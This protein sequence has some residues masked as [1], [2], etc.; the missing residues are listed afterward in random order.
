MPSSG[1]EIPDKSAGWKNP[2]AAPSL[3]N[4]VGDLAQSS[5]PM[6]S[7]TWLV[8]IITIMLVVI[9]TI[10]LLVIEII[11]TML[12]VMRMMSRKKMRLQPQLLLHIRPASILV[13]SPIV[14]KKYI[15]IVVINNTLI[16][17]LMPSKQYG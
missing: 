13:S 9:I 5:C 15:S 7:C 17:T 2:A 1:G 12:V 4:V 14:V 8:I 3:L 6:S 11:T 16:Y 10:M